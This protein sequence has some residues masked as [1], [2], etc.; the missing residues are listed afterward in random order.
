MPVNASTS[1]AATI[2][3]ETGYDAGTIVTDTDENYVFTSNILDGS[4]FFSRVWNRTMGGH[5]PF[6][7]QP[8]KDN[9]N[10][11]QFAIARFVGN[12]LQYDQVANNVYNVKLK[13]REC[14]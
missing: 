11:D 7:F 5:L 14:W 4:D 3:S 2:G 9:S 1:Y 8:N 10:P 13:I 6:I 12:S